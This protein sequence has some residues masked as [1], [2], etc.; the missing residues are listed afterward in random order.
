[1]HIVWWVLHCVGHTK[2]KATGSRVTSWSHQTES[3][4]NGCA[5]YGSQW[6]GKRR[7]QKSK[8]LVKKQLT[9]AYSGRQSNEAH[10]QSGHIRLQCTLETDF[11]SSYSFFANKF[12]LQLNG[13]FWNVKG[14]FQ[15]KS[16]L[17]V[18]FVWTVRLQF[19]PFFRADNF[20][21]S[22]RAVA[23]ICLHSRSV[24]NWYRQFWWPERIAVS[25]VWHGVCNPI[26]MGAARSPLFD[27]TSTDWTQSICCWHITCL[28]KSTLFYRQFFWIKA[29]CANKAACLHCVTLSKQLTPSAV[30]KCLSAGQCRAEICRIWIHKKFK[31]LQ[32]V[33]T[34]NCLFDKRVQ[35]CFSR[36]ASGL[37]WKRLKF[38][39]MCLNLANLQKF[40]H[41]EDCLKSHSKRHHALCPVC[42]NGNNSLEINLTN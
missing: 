12:G 19:H 15:W 31:Q 24:T 36:I 18:F 1:M 28:N 23:V 14:C 8:E 4:Y 20:I 37:R 25:P 9:F 10:S 40:S 41:N 30:E 32:T 34:L 11:F 5:E 35:R 29:W 17:E 6:Y 33:R 7:R 38:R 2:R 22:N 26:P 16:A 13:S 39:K 21:N 27:R 42:E 3:A